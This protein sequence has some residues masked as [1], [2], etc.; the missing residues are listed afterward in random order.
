MMMLDYYEYTGDK[1]FARQTLLPVATAGLTFFALHF[2]HDAMG[3]LVLDPDNAIE[4]YWMAHNPAPDIAGLH[5]IL[6]RLLALPQGMVD[7][8]TRD[9]WKKLA[10]EL[11][12][13]PKGTV[14]GSEVLLPYEGEQTMTGNNIENPELYSIYPFRLYG[15][16][17]P[18]LEV[19]LN[20][21]KIRKF[22][23]SG[24]WVQDP[25]Q[26]AM[27]G[28]TDEA[29]KDV[30]F[31]L[32]RKDSR[33]KF[34]A[35]WSRGHDYLPDEDNGGNGGNGLQEM[36]MQIDGRKILLLP[37]WPSDWNAEFKLHAP[38]R[39]TVQGRVVH[40][41]LLDLQIT[42]RSRAADVTIP[43]NGSH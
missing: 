43:G 13:L 10:N 19:A 22:K 33:L 36:L 32:T 15:L 29:R 37:A 7:E 17:R 39:T 35:F 25:I 28:L 1:T 5:A 18:D 16:S 6:P 38:F 41:K 14:N 30:T 3:K 12:D 21:W 20:T 23:G 11:P 26:A 8:V 9:Q 4:M 31:D 27:L 2:P 34:P 40:G 24:C 42:P